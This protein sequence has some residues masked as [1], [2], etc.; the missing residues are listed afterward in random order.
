M[1]L[2]CDFERLIMDKIKTTVLFWGV[3]E[4]YIDLFL[5]E[6]IA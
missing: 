1:L 6:G 4:D 2:T 3:L 5:S